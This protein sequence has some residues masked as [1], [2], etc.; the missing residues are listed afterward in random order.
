MPG[1]PV[2]TSGGDAVEA[3]KALTEAASARQQAHD[4]DPDHTDR[5]WIDEV[6]QF[7]HAELSAFY[8]QKLSAEQEADVRSAE[9]KEASIRTRTVSVDAIDL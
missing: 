9:R 4:A 2:S 1:G 7:P 5:A 8:E 3:R 6:S